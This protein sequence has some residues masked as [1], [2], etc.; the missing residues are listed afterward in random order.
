[1]TL[2]RE[3]EVVADAEVQHVHQRGLIRDGR[4]RAIV[5]SAIE[6]APRIRDLVG[7]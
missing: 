1:V 6:Q 7:S 2:R 4:Y 3:P 5:E